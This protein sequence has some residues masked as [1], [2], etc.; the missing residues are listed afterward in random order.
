MSKTYMQKEDK[1]G[2]RTGKIVCC[3]LNDW[4]KYRSDGFAFVESDEDGNTPEAQFQK[5]NN[6]APAAAKKTA[7]KK[8]S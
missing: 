5:Q 6:K 2:K 7:G 3:A 8:K 1:D 4:A